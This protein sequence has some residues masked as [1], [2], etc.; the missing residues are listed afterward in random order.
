MPPVLAQSSSGVRFERSSLA[1]QT[2]S[3]SHKFSIEIASTER[4]QQH[5]LMFRRRM[6]ADAGMLFIYPVPQVITMW[7][8]NTYIPLD[9]L[10]IGPDGTIVSIVQRAI[11][12]SLETISSTE[13]AIAVLEVNGGTV[14]R[15]KI[16]RGDRINYPAFQGTR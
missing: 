10:F 6:A 4:Q 9:M 12:G 11:P 14:S 16:K 13:P 3:K 2:A 5:G 1:I 7:M 15:L 8:K